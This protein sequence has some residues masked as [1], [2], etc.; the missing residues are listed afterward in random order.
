[1]SLLACA[2]LPG[3]AFSAKSAPAGR[4]DAIL[5]VWV[6]QEKDAHIEIYRQGDAYFGKIVW[7]REP[8]G[9]DAG[10]NGNGLAA[11]K[12]VE[13]P[14]VGLV[15]VRNFR[16]DGVAWRGGTLYDPQDGKSYQGVL[17]LDTKGALHVRG[18]IGISLLGRTTVWQR[19]KQ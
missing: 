1:M 5:G 19:V 15:I 2:A 4:G 3:V 18:F 6:V 9:P 7:L 13:T 8:E 17:T 12:M 14:R 10:E 11:E 16:F